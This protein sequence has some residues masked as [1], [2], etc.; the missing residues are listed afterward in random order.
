MAARFK[1]SGPFNVPFGLLI[2]SAA[3][4]HGVEQ[5]TFPDPED[6]PESLYF[7][8]TFRTFGGTE[9]T[10]NGLY[11]IEDTATVETWY[12]PDITAACRI[13]RR[14]TGAI[15]DIIGTPEDINARR[16]FLVLKI[17]AVE[18]GA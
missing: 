3:T 13:F 2:P 6:V 7:F 8:G 18:S 14:D 16:Q 9:M 12:R 4:V 1:P 11:A 17:R 5:K 15:Y 10:V